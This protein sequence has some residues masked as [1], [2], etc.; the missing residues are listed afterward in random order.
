MLEVLVFFFAGLLICAGTP[1]GAGYFL[2]DRFFANVDD[3]SEIRVALFFACVVLGPIIG[4]FVLMPPH[5]PE[6]II[7]I[8]TLLP[9]ASVI[10]GWFF[11]HKPQNQEPS[12]AV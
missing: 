1:F 5:T 7:G 8:V 11:G 9:I 4:W 2:G 10:V 6:W 12:L 3:K